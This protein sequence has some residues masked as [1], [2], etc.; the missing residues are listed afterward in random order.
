MAS[1]DRHRNLSLKLSD[2]ELARIHALARAGDES[3]GRM[4]RRWIANE[5]EARFGD[6]PPP[7]PKL[8]T[9][10]RTTAKHRRGHA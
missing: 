5:Y 9:A 3:V 2:P 1:A 6:A 10:R 8:R 4:V 7:N